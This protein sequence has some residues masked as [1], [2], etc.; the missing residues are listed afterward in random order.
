MFAGHDLGAAD[1]QAKFVARLHFCHQQFFCSRRT[2]A[3]LWH[4]CEVPTASSKVRFQ[5]QP[6]RHLLSLSSSQ[7]LSLSSSQFDP[8]ATLAGSKFR[9]A[10]VSYATVRCAIFDTGSTWASS[11][12]VDSE[13]FRSIPRTCWSL[14]RRFSV[15]QADQRRQGER[16]ARCL[17]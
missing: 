3:C 8:S 1:W 11:A 12:S 5:G 10:A 4:F 15:R 9:S 17:A 13:Q 14:C 6:G 2:E 16:N 7:L